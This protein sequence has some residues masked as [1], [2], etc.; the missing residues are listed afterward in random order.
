MK[1]PNPESSVARFG[2][3]LATPSSGGEIC[4]NTGGKNK[5]QYAYWETRNGAYVWRS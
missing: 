5:K 4:L 3:Y 2:L 1:F